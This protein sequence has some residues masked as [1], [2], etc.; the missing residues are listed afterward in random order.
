V[1]ADR[2]NLASRVI[3][4]EVRNL[5]IGVAGL[6]RE[7]EPFITFGVYYL[8]TSVFTLVHDGTLTGHVRFKG[9]ELLMQPFVEGGVE[10]PHGVYLNL[11]IKVP[12]S[13]SAAKAVRSEIDTGNDLTFALQ[14]LR[15]ELRAKEDD[16]L[17]PVKIR[18]W[19]HTFPNSWLRGNLWENGAKV[20]DGVPSASAGFRN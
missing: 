20:I 15:F 5:G 1:Q 8:N 2:E 18:L 19:E 7:I 13:E 9:E 16:S 10:I 14:G 6:L 12:L 4:D 11:V 17:S 3:L